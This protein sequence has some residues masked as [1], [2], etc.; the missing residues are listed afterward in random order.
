MFSTSP[1]CAFPSDRC[2]TG[3]F[4]AFLFLKPGAT[5]NE[6][7]CP[8]WNKPS[9]TEAH[10]LPSPYDQAEIRVNISEFENPQV[11]QE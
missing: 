5:S 4:S 6:E 9:D 1:L 7:S 11:G 2:M 10:L 3:R 8:H